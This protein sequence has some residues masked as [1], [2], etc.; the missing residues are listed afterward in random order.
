MQTEHDNSNLV[1][2][3]VRLRGPWLRGPMVEGDSGQVGYSIEGI[4]V[5]DHQLMSRSK[6]SI[7]YAWKLSSVGYCRR[8]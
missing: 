4:P 3:G 5:K 8:I 6:A 7:D 2:R 1:E